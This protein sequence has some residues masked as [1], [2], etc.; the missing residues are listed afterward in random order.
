MDALGWI[1]LSIIERLPSFG[2]KMY[3]HYIGWY[4][5]KC[6]LFGELAQRHVYIDVTRQES[7]PR[8]V[9]LLVDVVCM[10]SC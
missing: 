8:A 10:S 5:G 2:G 7:N 6:P 9:V 4:I 1:I 3:C